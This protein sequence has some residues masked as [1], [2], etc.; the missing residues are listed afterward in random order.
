MSFIKFLNSI[1]K[2]SASDM[3]CDEI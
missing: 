1:D 3:V 2:S